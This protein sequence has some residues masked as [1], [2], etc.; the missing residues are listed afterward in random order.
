MDGGI[1]LELV[2]IRLKE[3]KDE[4]FIYNSWLQSN[5]SKHPNIPASDYYSIYKKIIADALYKSIVVIA[6][7]RQDPE[8]IYGYA[9]IRPIDDVKIIH[10][11]YVKKPFRRFGLAKQMLESQDINLKDP[12]IVT[13]KAPEFVK[14]YTLIY[15]PEL[16][17]L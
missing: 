17:T 1:L 7:N 4:P 15:K 14:G 5:K 8:F 13:A 10:Y 2:A 3:S 6:C 9:V 16:K 12:V 11:V